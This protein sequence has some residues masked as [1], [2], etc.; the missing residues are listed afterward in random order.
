MT[1]SNFLGFPVPGWYTSRMAVVVTPERIVDSVASPASSGRLMVVR[2][3]GPKPVRN[4]TA[5]PRHALNFVYRA[6]KCLSSFSFTRCF[7]S[8]KKRAASVITRSCAHDGGPRRQCMVRLHHET[9]SN[10]AL[11]SATSSKFLSSEG[12]FLRDRS[13]GPGSGRQNAGVRWCMVGAGAPCSAGRHAS[14]CSSPS[15][16][17]HTLASTIQSVTSA[18]CSSS[19]RPCRREVS[20]WCNM[21]ASPRCPDWTFLFRSSRFLSRSS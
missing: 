14:G 20:S 9:S 1:A 11:I 19:S 15:G 18:E 16:H 6:V 13:I 4:R 3:P 5:L 17:T 21:S 12:K 8:G 7:A 2:L 10:K